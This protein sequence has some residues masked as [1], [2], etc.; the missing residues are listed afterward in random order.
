MKLDLESVIDYFTIYLWKNSLKRA[1]QFLFIIINYFGSL[2]KNTNLNSYD[3]YIFNLID[4]FVYKIVFL[5]KIMIEDNSNLIILHYNNPWRER[6]RE[7]DRDRDRENIN[8][9]NLDIVKNCTT[10]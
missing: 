10:F 5:L 8:I 9:C 1:N 2:F 7:R 3:Q 4:C 6:E